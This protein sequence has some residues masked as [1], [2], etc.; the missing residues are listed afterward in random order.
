M[1]SMKM[2]ENKDETIN[3]LGFKCIEDE[4]DEDPD[5]IDFKMENKEDLA[6]VLDDLCI[7]TARGKAEFQKDINCLMEHAVAGV[8]GIIVSMDRGDVSFSFDVLKSL[9][10][11]VKAPERY[12]LDMSWMKDESRI[13]FKLE[14]LEKLEDF[15]IVTFKLT[16]EFEQMRDAMGF[17]DTERRAKIQKVFDRVMWKSPIGA[18]G[19]I[20]VFKHEAVFFHYDALRKIGYRIDEPNNTPEELAWFSARKTRHRRSAREMG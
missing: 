7:R 1:E 13:H 9:G 19:L 6:W 20:I 8:T 10:F 2:K 18:E 11:R 5:I 16:K 3:A 14:G 15:G 17:L 12:D 4:Y